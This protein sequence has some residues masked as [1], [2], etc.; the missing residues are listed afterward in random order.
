MDSAAISTAI[1]HPERRGSRARR[2]AIQAVSL[3]LVLIV[4][5]AWLALLR[6]SSLGG[7]ATY[8]IVAGDSMRP[9]LQS[10]DLVVAFEQDSYTAGDVIVYRVP[11]AEPGA[12]T[13]IVHRIVGGS[14]GTGFLVKGDSRE[15]ADYSRPRTEEIVGKM[16]LSVPSVGSVLVFLRTPAG[17]ALI[18]GLTTLLIA[19]G[20]SAGPSRKTGETS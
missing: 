15:H 11:A 10:G 18:A 8:V 14:A 17:I 5:G 13:H 20:V 2:R 9:T 7:P 12:G 4:A 6:P 3:T 1:G 19:L 16:R